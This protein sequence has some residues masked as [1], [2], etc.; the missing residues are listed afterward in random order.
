M[1][2]EAW[3][4]WNLMGDAGKLETWERFQFES[5]GSLLENQEEQML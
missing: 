1:I 4:F 3:L 5:K 2:M